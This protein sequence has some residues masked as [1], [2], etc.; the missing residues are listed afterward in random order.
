MWRWV[1]QSKQDLLWQRGKTEADNFNGRIAQMGKE[2]GIPTPFS[3]ALTEIV[4]EMAAKKMKPGIHTIDKLR[5][6]V[7]AKK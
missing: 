1:I 5:E 3:E 2:V 6:L 7:E 4:N